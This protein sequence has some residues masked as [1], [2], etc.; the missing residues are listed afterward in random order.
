MT[1]P[2][3]HEKPK[4]KTIIAM[5]L[6]AA[7]GIGT[8]LY[9]WNL[10]P[11][12]S[13][14]VRT[15][16]AYLRGNVTVL[17]PQVSGYVVQ[18]YVADF[19]PVKA[20]ELI[21]RIDQCIYKARVAQAEAQL[22]ARRLD[23]K[24]TE[25][26]IATNRATLLSRQA[27]L[28]AALSEH[29][30]AGKDAKRMAAIVS[31]GAVSRR[32]MDSAR[33]AAHAAESSVSQVTAAIAIA[34][35]HVTSALIAR[36]LAKVAIENALATLELAMIDLGNT[37]IRAPKD[38]V[39]GE[40]SVK[41]GQ[42]VNAGSQ[43]LYLV[44]DSIWLTANYKETQT[45]RMRL[46]QRARFTVDALDHV[47]F[48]GQVERM[49]PATGSEFSLLKSDN[50]TGN[51]TKVVQRVPVRIS[52]DPGQQYAERLKPGMSVVVRVDTNDE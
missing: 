41:L 44:P 13:N 27:E 15:E 43:L 19:Q 17:A 25:Q 42:Y 11:F 47:E 31:Q 3:E 28:K 18:V 30:R 7:L 50:A 48:T 23:L 16:N 4:K 9:A 21:I 32:E 12:V 22:A 29:D 37:E 26:T 33:T 46:G 34:E 1:T 8:I 36:D 40:V 5:I 24:N 52:I 49:A 35:E 6:V 51:F 45:A 14:D 39:L 38:G 10:W 2:P 20:G